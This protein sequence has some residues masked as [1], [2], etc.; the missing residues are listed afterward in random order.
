MAVKSKETRTIINTLAREAL[1]RSENEWG[2]ERQARAENAFFAW[3]KDYVTRGPRNH[4]GR[5]AWQRFEDWALK[6]TT[7]EAV[8]EALRG[9]LG[10]HRHP[11]ENEWR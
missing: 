7:K 9:L 6:A 1:P 2:S 5:V 10:M 3:V 4:S 11:G 8:E